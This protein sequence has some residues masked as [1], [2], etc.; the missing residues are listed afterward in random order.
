LRVLIAQRGF[1]FDRVQ[2]FCKTRERAI[3]GTTGG[4]RAPLT[5]LPIVLAPRGSAE[6]IADKENA[7]RECEGHAWRPTLIG[8]AAAPSS[9]AALHFPHR[10]KCRTLAPGHKPTVNPRCVAEADMRV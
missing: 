2:A 6:R 4:I 5:V 8:R 10:Q 3:G 9:G 1:A 7:K